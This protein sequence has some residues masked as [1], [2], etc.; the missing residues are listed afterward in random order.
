MRLE[1]PAA[2][3]HTTRARSFGMTHAERAGEGNPD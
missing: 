3:A 2:A 1:L